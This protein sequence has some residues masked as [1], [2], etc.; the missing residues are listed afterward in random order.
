M[1]DEEQFSHRGNDGKFL[2]FMV[3]D[4]PLIRGPHRLV[5]LNAVEGERIWGHPLEGP[6]QETILP[7][8]HEPD[9]LADPI[10]VA[11]PAWFHAI[12]P[13]FRTR[14]FTCRASTGL[15]P[16]FSTSHPS[17]SRFLCEPLPS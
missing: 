6:C 13:P 8:L 10:P 17:G 3:A 15:V 16:T 2:W 11:L 1:G 7:L 14:Y 12:L 5:V 9:G 4:E